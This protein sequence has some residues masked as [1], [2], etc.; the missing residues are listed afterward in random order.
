MDA[1][2]FTRRAYEQ[3]TV[4]E[5][6]VHSHRKSKN[7][8]TI[9]K[10][11]GGMSIFTYGSDSIISRIH[12]VPPTISNLFHLSPSSLPLQSVIFVKVPQIASK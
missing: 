5:S 8:V 9:A 3:S 6:K 12:K 2:D 7:Y 4:A 10:Q 11:F 1:E